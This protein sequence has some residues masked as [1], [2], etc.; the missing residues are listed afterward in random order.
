[1]CRGSGSIGQA[2]SRQYSPDHY[3]L[4]RKSRRAVANGETRCRLHWAYG[5]MSAEETSIRPRTGP[6]SPRLDFPNLN[7]N[8]KKPLS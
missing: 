8:G 1:M 5:I 3:A 6:D 2:V 4:T 7:E